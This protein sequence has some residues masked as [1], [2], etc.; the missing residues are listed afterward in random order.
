MPD[1]ESEH[2]MGREIGNPGNQTELVSLLWKAILTLL[3]VPLIVVMAARDP[4]GTGHLVALL[5]T[6]GAKL[7]TAVADFLNALLGSHNH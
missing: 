2:R 7:L 4:Q 5:I 3:V 1:R 6:A